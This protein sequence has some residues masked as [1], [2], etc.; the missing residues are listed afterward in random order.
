MN[1]MAVLK[2]VEKLINEAEEYKEL[3]GKSRKFRI[4]DVYKDLSIFDWWN[5]YLSV[6]QLKQMRKFL[7]TAYELGFTK[8]VCFKVGAKE[9]SHGMWAHKEESTNGY[10]PKGDCL[11][12]SFR[13]G[14]N[15]WDGKI[16]GEWLHSKYG[17]YKFTVEQIILDI[18]REV[19]NG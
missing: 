17:E 16:N 13:N 19:R 18:E 12:H 1:N 11:Y 7:I 14:D 4:D 10:S 6:P 5:N 2:N 15:Y 9:C 3:T 8:Y